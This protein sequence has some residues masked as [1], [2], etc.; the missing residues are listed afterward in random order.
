MRRTPLLAA[1]LITVACHTPAPGGADSARAAAPADTQP[2]SPAPGDSASAAPVE[3]RTDKSTY[4]AGEEMTLTLVSRADVGYSFNPCT[5]T[6]ERETAGGW[7]AVD[8]G[9]RICT[10]EAW[11]LEPRGTRSGPTALP[12]QM[13]PGRYRVSLQLIAETQTPPAERARITSAPFTVQP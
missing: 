11:L 8:E 13:E 7:S 4:R 3:L 12:E 5:R 10:M 1:L 6:L 9:E 2:L